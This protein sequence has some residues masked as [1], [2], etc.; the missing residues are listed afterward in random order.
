MQLPAL[1]VFGVHV[2]L[3]LDATPPRSPTLMRCDFGFFLPLAH[4]RTLALKP[5]IW[6]GLGNVTTGRSLQSQSG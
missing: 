3:A 6:V 4:T 2:Y 5:R 1:V